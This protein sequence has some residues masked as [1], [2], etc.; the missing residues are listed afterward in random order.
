[1]SEW[2]KEARD[3]YAKW[4]MVDMSH[5]EFFRDPPRV[6]RIDSRFFF[7][8][9]DGIIISQSRVS[10]NDDL[11]ETKG[12]HCTLAELL[13]PWEIDQPC[14]CVSIFLTFW[15]VHIVRMS[16]GGIIYNQHVGPRR[17]CNAPMLFEENGILKKGVIS[18][19]DQRYMASN[20]RMLSRITSTNLTYTYYM[21]SL[22]DSDISAIL[23]FDHR[24]RAPLAQSERCFAVR[25][26]SQA[27]LVLPLDP[28][29]KFKTLCQITDHVEAGVDALVS[30]ER[31]TKGQH[32]VQ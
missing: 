17:S 30:I 10:P 29:Y 15:D 5:R 4:P 14:L 21:V 20:A 16:T 8:P 1:M 6:Q 11:L 2:L 23:P 3:K 18:K 27:T 7:S 28:R 31:R 19:A 9:A 12:T 25:W 13:S 22:A 32:Y 26:G 24:L